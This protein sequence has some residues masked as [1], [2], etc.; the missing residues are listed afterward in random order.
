LD[1]SDHPTFGLDEEPALLRGIAVFDVKVKLMKFSSAADW[2]WGKREREDRASTH[3]S[4]ANPTLPANLLSVGN[5]W[6]AEGRLT[7]AARRLAAV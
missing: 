7:G 2:R 3:H 1:A 5:W 6:E 4:K